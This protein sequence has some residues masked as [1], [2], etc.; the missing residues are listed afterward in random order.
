[1][2][3]GG[4]RHPAAHN[5]RP[6]SSHHSEPRLAMWPQAHPH[7]NAVST[8]CGVLHPCWLL[9]GQPLAIRSPLILEAADGAMASSDGDR[10][11]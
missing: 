5:E 7:P 3:E 8:R 11:P 1:M 4:A 10:S 9:R 2:L 6:L